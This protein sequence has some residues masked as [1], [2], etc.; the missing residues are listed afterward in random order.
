MSEKNFVIN[1]SLDVDGVTID[2]TNSQTGMSLHRIGTSVTAKHE[3][4]IG[5]VTM[6]AGHIDGGKTNLPAG[7]LLCDGSETAVSSYPALDA[8]VGTRYGSRTDGSG[9]AGTSHFRLPN[10][11][12][13][14]PIGHIGTNSDA[15]NSIN[16][17]DN[18]LT[19]HQHTF[20][21]TGVASNIGAHQHNVDGGNSSHNHGASSNAQGNASHNLPGAGITHTHSYS[22]GTGNSTSTGFADTN[23]GHVMDATNISHAHN[24]DAGGSSANHQHGTSQSA[25][26]G[27]THSVTM[28]QS[29]DGQTQ[30]NDSH[31]HGTGW[32]TVKVFFIIKAL[33]AV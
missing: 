27:H 20:Q 28:S 23:H 21:Y 30:N 6:F 16:S 26:L 17:T 22:R 18:S 25:N 3:T 8:V 15:P 31:S 14:L 12:D 4:P 10:M 11:T 32:S 5:T 29:S 7:W 13:R 19:S 9:G 33:Q 2:L 1:G 24:N